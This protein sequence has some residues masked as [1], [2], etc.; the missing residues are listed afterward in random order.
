MLNK[1]YQCMKNLH[2]V[3]GEVMYSIDC[4]GDHIAKREGYKAFDGIDAVHYYLIQK[5]NWLPMQ[6]RSLN[7][8]DIKFL[9]EEEMHGWVLPKEA[10]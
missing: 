7:F 2:K 8:E 1:R 9:L 6:V 10:H 5:Y 4:F 3:E